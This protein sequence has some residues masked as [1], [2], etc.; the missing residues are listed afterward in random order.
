MITVTVGS[1][2][3]EAALLAAGYAKTSVPDSW[4]DVGSAEY[5]PKLIGGPAYDDWSNDSHHI[6]VVDGVVEGDEVLPPE[7]DTFPF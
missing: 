4:Q 2:V 1:P 6:Y 5:G 3:D 7:P